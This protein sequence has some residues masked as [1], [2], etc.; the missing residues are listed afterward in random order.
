VC[1]FNSPTSLLGF[2]NKPNRKFLELCNCIL[3]PLGIK[4]PAILSPGENAHRLENPLLH[5]NSQ[6]IPLQASLN[7]MELATTLYNNKN[8]I[9][10]MV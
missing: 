9:M 10:D 5:L 1:P 6:Q 7:K 8:N 3:T 2:N 4:F